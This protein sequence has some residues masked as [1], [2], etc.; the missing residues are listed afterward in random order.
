MT[1]K[2]WRIEE[3]FPRFVKA[4]AARWLTDKTIKTNRLPMS[5]SIG[6][7]ELLWSICDSYALIRPLRRAPSPRGRQKK[8]P[9]DAGGFLCWHSLSSWAGQRIV[10][11]EKHSGG[12]F[13]AESGY[14]QKRTR[15]KSGSFS[16]CWHYLSSRAV[17]RQVLSA[18]MSLT[19]VFGMGTGGPS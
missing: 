3:A 9:A 1:Q 19:S 10:L 15:P 5:V 13:P 6:H 18:Y 16:L 17:T 11:P 8:P 4:Q 2:S 12:V 7:N 14:A